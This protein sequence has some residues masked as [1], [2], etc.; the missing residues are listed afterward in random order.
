[1]SKSGLRN[2][3]VSFGIILLRAVLTVVTA[4]LGL[5]SLAV[6][7]TLAVRP[8]LFLAFKPFAVRWWESI[9]VISG[10]MIWLV[11]VYLWAYLYQ[12]VVS[13]KKLL[14]N[15]IFITF[16]QGLVPL[17]LLGISMTVA[18]YY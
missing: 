18:R 9:V 4:V 6:G 2:A 10:V 3:I 1:M 17:F 16:M 5:G 8:L 14:L 15:F 7:Y 12:R 13:L 11:L